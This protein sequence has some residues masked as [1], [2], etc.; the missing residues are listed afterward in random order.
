MSL[1]ADLF[2]NGPSLHQYAPSVPSAPPPRPCCRFVPEPGTAGQREALRG[3]SV[4]TAVSRS[5]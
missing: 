3:K 1:T 2:A 4:A 5:P